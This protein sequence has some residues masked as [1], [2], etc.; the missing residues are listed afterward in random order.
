MTDADRPPARNLAAAVV[1]SLAAGPVFI[2]SYL[3]ALGIAGAGNAPQAVEPEAIAFAVGL[4]AVAVPFGLTIAILPCLIGVTA[5]GWLARQTGIGGLA[6]VWMLAGAVPIA[7]IVIAGELDAPFAFALAVTA[8]LC[9]LIA[10]RWLRV[11]EHSAPSPCPSPH[12]SPIC[13]R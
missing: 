7:P 1:A 10:R 5:M 12:G 2:A 6:P 13:P 4:M 3:L 8:A 9:A 11:A